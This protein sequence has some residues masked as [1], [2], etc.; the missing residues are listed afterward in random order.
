MTIQQLLQYTIQHG[1]SDLHLVVDSPPLVRKDG[2]LIAV[3]GEE[4]L[5][6]ARVEQLVGGVVSVEQKQIL[7]VNKEIDF[8]FSFGDQARFRVNAYFQ[9]GTQAASFR[10]ISAKIPSID[11][12][13][14]PKICHD[15]TSL[16][17]GF[18]LVTGPT[19]HGKSTTLAA[20]LE[21]INQTRPVHIVSI[22]DPIEYVYSAARSVVSQRE[23][24]NDTHSWEI[25]LRSVLREDPDVVLIGEMRDFETIAAALTIA[26]TGHLVFATLHTNSASQTLDRIVDVFPENQQPQVRAQLS[27][28]LEA[29]F[30]QR[31]IPRIGGGRVLGYEIMVGT[32]AVR[33]AIREGRTHMLDNIIMTSAEYGMVPMEGTLAKLVKDGVLSLELAQAYSIRPADVLRYVKGGVG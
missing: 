12:L 13:G 8:S 6:A 25:A 11:S 5:S 20:I 16:K 2:A 33:T 10:W 31:L 22:E 18:V 17:Q 32:S 4:K 19:G 21:E 29:V 27:A 23:V 15:F 24:H 14:L 30:S 3:A 26:E 7:L 9:R 1:A 28:N